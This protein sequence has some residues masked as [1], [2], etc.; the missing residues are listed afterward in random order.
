M[1]IKI[2]LGIEKGKFNN[3]RLN[4]GREKQSK[5]GKTRKTR[6]QEK[7]EGKTRETRKVKGVY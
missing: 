5:Q 4:T 1:P 2:V 3:K 7:K 6:K